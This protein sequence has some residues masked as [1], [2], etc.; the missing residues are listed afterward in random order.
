MT[1]GVG[2]GEQFVHGGRRGQPVRGA[3]EVDG[4]RD[5]NEDEVTAVVGKGAAA[6]GTRD[7]PAGKPRQDFVPLGLGSLADA[8]RWGAVDLDDAGA[9]ALRMGTVAVMA[10]AQ[11]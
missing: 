7:Q 5:A 10:A 2:M 4:G 6:G 1:V 11:E 9:R 8:A 3:V